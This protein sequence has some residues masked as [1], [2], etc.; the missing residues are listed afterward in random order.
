MKISS[1][2]VVLLRIGAGL[3]NGA[4]NDFGVIR[5]MERSAVSSLPN[6]TALCVGDG[7]SSKAET[8]HTSN[9]AF[10]HSEMDDM[11]IGENSEL[12]SDNCA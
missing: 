5:R 9:F 7:R 2:T 4:D 6:T 1:P 12:V 8:V 10:G 11:E 3:S